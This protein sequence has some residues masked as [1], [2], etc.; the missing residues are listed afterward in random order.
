MVIVEARARSEK[1]GK[2]G[3]GQ[4]FRNSD[5]QNLLMKIQEVVTTDQPPRTCNATSFYG[6][7]H[8]VKN[9]EYVVLV[10]VVAEIRDQR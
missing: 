9:D 8:T 5:R 7:L 1:F 2:L 4:C 6:V 10:E 3:L